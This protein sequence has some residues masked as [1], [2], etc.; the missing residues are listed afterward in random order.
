MQE[1]KPGENQARLREL[2]L[3][4]KNGRRGFHRYLIRVF[5]S[6]VQLAPAP[7]VASNRL[8]VQ[9]I[10]GRKAAAS[11]DFAFANAS[12]RATLCGLLS[13]PIG[14]NKDI[15]ATLAPLQ[16]PSLIKIK[17]NSCKLSLARYYIITL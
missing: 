1:R 11:S 13:V 5:C 2:R 8:C 6:R 15:A 16:P 10:C 7:S 17:L 9:M 4:Q 14:C 12:L 3:A